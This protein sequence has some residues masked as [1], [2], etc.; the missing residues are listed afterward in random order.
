MKVEE[1]SPAMGRPRTFDEEEAL[2]KALRVFW[3]K[4]YEGASLSDLTT[5]MGINRPSLYAA[6]GNKE[7]LFQ[8]ALARYDATYMRFVGEALAEPTA[9]ATAER[10]LAGCANLQTNRG[11]P[12]GCLGLN[13]ALACGTA[14]DPIRKVMV[15]RRAEGLAAFRR[16]FARAKAEG[17]LPAD[18]SPGD[19]AR[20]VQTVSQG[21][22]VQAA[23]GAT[24]ADLHRVVELAMKAWPG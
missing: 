2:E 10:F 7:E 15:A 23:S 5:A 24:R 6:F 3:E 17:E 9:R 21:M 12:R 4:G 18:A 22:A 1:A 11:D 8:K 16:R 13:G 14:A 20:Y 19:L